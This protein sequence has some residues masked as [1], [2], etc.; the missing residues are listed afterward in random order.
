MPQQQ[1]L[2]VD[3]G[4][5]TSRDALVFF[6]PVSFSAAMVLAHDGLRMCT[7]VS[8]FLLSF[9]QELYAVAVKEQLYSDHHQQDAALCFVRGSSFPSVLLDAQKN[10]NEMVL[11]KQA[12]LELASY[13]TCFYSKKLESAI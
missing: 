2:V 3:L 8:S 9:N 10:S 5:S 4:N 6:L 11:E 7:V 13:Q 12:P 1:S